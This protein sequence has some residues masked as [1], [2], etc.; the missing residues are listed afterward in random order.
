MCFLCI[1]GK[2]SVSAQEIKGN[3]K[4]SAGTPIIDAM[5]STPA[6]DIHAHSDL[7]GNFTCK[8]VDVGDTILITFLGFKTIVKILE[9]SDFNTFHNFVLKDAFFELDQ[10]NISNSMKMTS[11]VT[12]IDLSTAP[13]TSSQEVLVRVPGLVIAQHAGGGKAEQIFLRGFDIDHGTDITIGVDGLPVNMVSH[14]HGQG[15]A[16]LHFLIPET[17]ENIDFGKGPYYADKGNFNTAGYVNFKTKDQLDNSVF[18]LEYGAFNSTR[19]LTMLDLLG[20]SENQNA[21]IASEF[22]QGDGPFE[23]PQNFNRL[24]VMG[25]YIL[26]FNKYDRL[27]VTMSRFQSKWDASGQIPQRLVDNGTISRFGSVDDTEGGYTSRTNFHI[28]YTK[29]LSPTKF[30]KTKAFYSKYDFELFSN[31]TFYLEDPI[32]GDQIRQH[33]NRNIYGLESILFNTINGKKMDTEIQ[34]GAGLRYDDVDDNELS[35]TTN[36]QELRNRLAY[37]DVDET[38]LYG[39]VNFELEWNKWLINTGVRLDYFT[40]NYV[41]NLAPQYKTLSEQL[42]FISPKLNFIYNPNS[43]VQFFLKSGLG[44]HSNDTRVVVAN[45][46]KEILPGAYGLD[47]GSTWKPKSRMWLTASLWYLYLDQEFVYVGDAAIVEPSGKTRREGV[48]LGLRYQFADNLFFNSDFSYTLARAIGEPEGNNYI[49]LAPDFILSGSLTYKSQS[50]I[51]GGLNYRYI[52]DRPANEDNS[53]IAK[54]YFLV[55]A[56][57]N[58]KYKDVTFGLRADNLLDTEW[59]E[60]Q[61]ATE[62]RLFNESEPVEELHFTP[63]VPLSLRGSVSYQF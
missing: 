62:S 29:V 11:K 22:L 28:D 45:E 35:Y 63:G 17:I 51:F 26:D 47:L 23:S 12:S 31:F 48:E 53:I 37:G 57:I 1:L 19:I 18:G 52:K 20:S 46:G 21:Y 14:A 3:I 44:F 15:Y 9:K 54:G 42:G 49:P 39:F 43:S 56:N 16:D 10:V 5:I 25:K 7:L 50:G 6:M 59:N 8:G 55:N 60:S 4:N 2:I 61:F 30:I 34:I 24:N 41:D 27:S 58:Y 36:R 33:E 13:V 32:N 38:N 40:F